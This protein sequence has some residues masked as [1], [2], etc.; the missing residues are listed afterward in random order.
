[1]DLSLRV[2]FRGHNYRGSVFYAIATRT[3]HLTRPPRHV[4][5]SPEFFA[6]LGL[7]ILMSLCQRLQLVPPT[8]TQPQPHTDLLPLLHTHIVNPPELPKPLTLL[9]CPAR[10]CAV[11]SG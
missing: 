7:F 5:V 9:R 8:P 10:W 3:V 4:R 2:I 1:M 6:L 11:F